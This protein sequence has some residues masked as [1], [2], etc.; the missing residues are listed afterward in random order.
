MTVVINV[1][2]TFTFGSYVGNTDPD[3]TLLINPITCT[4]VGCTDPL[5]QSYTTGPETIDWLITDSLLLG[6]HTLEQKVSYL[7]YDGVDTTM[8][9]LTTFTVTIVSCHD[10]YPIAGNNGAP[11]T[12]IVFELW[13]FQTN[14]LTIAMPTAEAATVYPT[15]CQLIIEDTSANPDLVIMHNTPTVGDMTL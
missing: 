14:S 5:F 7:N 1:A 6:P 2:E 13:A 12:S 8:D 9:M 11:L 15:T 3:C 4:S 10:E